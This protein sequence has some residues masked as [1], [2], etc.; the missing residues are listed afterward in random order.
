VTSRTR[1]VFA[2][3]LVGVCAAPALAYLKLGVQINGRDVALQWQ[4][5]PVRYFVSDV[6]PAGV[7][8]TQVDQAIERAFRAWE[9]LSTSAIAF[10]RVGITPAPPRDD[11]GMNVIGFESHPELERV[12]GSTSLT[13]D[14]VTG[15]LLE[16]DI[17]LNS[18]F[19]WTTA[20]NGVSGRFDVESIALHEI[21]HL[22]GLSHSALGETELRPG[23]GRRVLGAGAVMFPIA[24]PAGSIE[25]R[26][27]RPDDIA[28][29]SDIYADGSFR[30]LTGSVSGR[31]TKDGRGVFGAHV[32]AFNLRTRQLVANFSLNDEG[33]YVIAGVDPG[34]CVIRVEP[35][36]DGDVEGFFDE[37][38]DV[39]AEFRATIHDELVI[40]PEGGDTG[41]VDIAVRTR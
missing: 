1:L 21:G 20:E 32:I 39:D 28:G 3:I 9:E 17:F 2:A 14:S 24:F 10:R 16:A 4:T 6:A 41:S 13:I 36:D 7:S 26:E 25:G 15:E 34:P 40:V 33:R 27:L 11:D 23:G 18:A 22:L 30:R 35:L 19:L 31:V 29:A 12:L 38:A 8:V 5:L 37:S